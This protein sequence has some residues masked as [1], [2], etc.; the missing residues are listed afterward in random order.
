MPG[1]EGAPITNG[2]ADTAANPAD[3]LAATYALPR[4]AWVT[5]GPLMVRQGP[6]L[7]ED[8]LGTL[9]ARTGVTV[10]GFSEDG[11]WSRIQ[12]PNAGWVSNGYLAFLSDGEVKE[13]VQLDVRQ[14]V[15]RAAL[16][17]RTL[18]DGAAPQAGVL[19]AGASIV[20]VARTLDGAW[21]QV[22][23]PLAGWISSQEL[24][25]PDSGAAAGGAP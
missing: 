18:P 3:Y 25:S 10:D 21:S 6:S 14:T 13:M 15:G 8:Y 24:P 23:Q 9:Q 17:V 7:T 20:V 11:A 5:E 2:I 19:P 22:V 12:E 16:V 1:S 4:I